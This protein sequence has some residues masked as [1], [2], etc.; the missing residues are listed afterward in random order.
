[1]KT[2]STF[3]KNHLALNREGVIFFFFFI[4]LGIASIYSGKSGLMLLWC[5]LFAILVIFVVM[6]RINFSQNL[7]IERRFVE[8]IFAGRD[9]RI[10]LVIENCGK[11][12]V[13][14]I[15][16]YECFDDGREI[17][18]MFIKKL[19][20]GEIAVARYMCVFPQRGNAHFCGYQLRSRFPLPFL[21]LRKNI[22]WEQNIP[23]FPQPIPGTELIQ[24]NVAAS[25]KL[26]K[27]FHR[28]KT[29]IRELV[30]GRRTGRILWKLSARK[31]TWL[32]EAPV[33]TRTNH[34]MPVIDLIEKSTLGSYHYERQISQITAFI[35][36]QIQQQ[37]NGELRIGNTRLPYGYSPHQRRVILIA[38]SRV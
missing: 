34:G 37:I 25:D 29:T 23:V 19:A 35:L 17:G 4:A 16:I 24:F 1:M 15:L 32:E 33:H 5:C 38:L 2:K 9:T 26:P 7:K 30:H 27:K 14:G 3:I 11:Q 21:E 20:P 10:D 6:A 31:Q 13:Y 8:E 12:T 36:S 28:K 18:P 22:D